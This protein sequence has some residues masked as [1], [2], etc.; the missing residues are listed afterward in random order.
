NFWGF[1]A[2]ER[3]GAVKNLLKAFAAL[4]LVALVVAP[5]PA[6]SIYGTLTGIV[7]DPSQSVIAGA[8]IKLRNELSGDQRETVTN[9][10]GY[11]TFVSVQPCGYE[12]NITSSG[13]ETYK[14]TGVA[15]RGGDKINV[16]VT[17]KLGSTANVVE[18]TGSIDLAVPTDSGEN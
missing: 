11:Y 9:A 7:S 6:Q 13:F 1:R 10:D 18:V 12:L 17:L 5:L 4:A 16:N 14:Q 2:T 3:G 15:I 8:K